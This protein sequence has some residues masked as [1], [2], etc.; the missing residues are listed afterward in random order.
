MQSR[1]WFLLI[2]PASANAST[3][4]VKLT[5]PAIFFFTLCALPCQC[6]MSQLTC[7]KRPRILLQRKAAKIPQSEA[8][9]T[10]SAKL[11][12]GCR[13]CGGSP[14]LLALP[15]SLLSFGQAFGGIMCGALHADKL[16]RMAKRGFLGLTTTVPCILRALFVICRHEILPRSHPY[17]T[18]L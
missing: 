12:T 7:D 14:N 15:L 3:D 4:Q 17:H 5:H 16:A 1:M 18:P 6:Q 9:R 8:P 13:C 10:I 11:R 2:S